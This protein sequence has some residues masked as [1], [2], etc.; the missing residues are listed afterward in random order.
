VSEAGFNPRN[1]DA[2][3]AQVAR[4]LPA[5]S[6]VL[7]VGAGPCRYRD[8][9]KHCEYETQDFCQYEK[10]VGAPGKPWA[11]GNIDHVSDVSAIPVADASFD[12]ILC[13]EVLEHVPEPIRALEE[14]ARILRT[15]GMLFVTAPLGCGLHQEPHHYYGGFTPHF[16][17]RFLPQ[18]GFEVLSIE[19]NGGFFRHLLQEIDRAASLIRQHR[20]WSRWNPMYYFLCRSFRRFLYGQL[21]RLDDRKP[22][23]E[24]T[25]GFHVRARRCP[26]RRG[27]G[28]IT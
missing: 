12:A 9:F 3:V 14:F 15:G 6:K 19:P 16:Y 23:V 4:S 26:A 8:L 22:L 1:R 24:F 21:T 2:W 28:S 18:L 7:D 5:D 13:T 11:Y 25:V 27:D 20:L 10:P 17:R